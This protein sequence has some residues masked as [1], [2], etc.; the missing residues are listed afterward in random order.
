[1]M[2]KEN[3]NLF[4]PPSLRSTVF[5][6]FSP[7]A[8]FVLMKKANTAFRMH[9]IFNFQGFLKRKFLDL[10]DGRV[11]ET[12][13]NV[14]EII[15]TQQSALLFH[16]APSKQHFFLFC[17]PQTP[18]IS[19][20]R[21]SV[22]VCALQ[23]FPHL[24][25][26][27]TCLSFAFLSGFVF[28][29]EMHSGVRVSRRVFS[30]SR[31]FHGRPFYVANAW[32][33]KLY[34]K[35]KNLMIFLRAAFVTIQIPLG[36]RDFINDI[37][38]LLVARFYYAPSLNCSKHIEPGKDMKWNPFMTGSCELHSK[39]HSLETSLEQKKMQHKVLVCIFMLQWTFFMFFRASL[40]T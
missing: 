35:G 7:N 6:L 40:H 23:F 22:G 34:I 20:R 39:A 8:R 21:D 28:V 38:K 25:N 14:V 1:M 12:P 26:R 36:L 16:S 32:M 30:R 13:C 18:S 37:V 10:S 27:T 11:C 2:K 31:P 29:R 17:F 5:L 19:G 9:Y 3:K 4:L 24:C 33:Q 15:W